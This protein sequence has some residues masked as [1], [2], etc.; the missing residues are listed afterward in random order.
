[1]PFDGK[2]GA[3]SIDAR[4]NFASQSLPGNGRFAVDPTRP[5]AQNSPLFGLDGA[6]WRGFFFGLTGV[7]ALVIG[8]AAMLLG[9]IG[10]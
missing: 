1:M 3:A 6:E 9:L 5:T 10:N 8:L 4:H 2:D 7:V